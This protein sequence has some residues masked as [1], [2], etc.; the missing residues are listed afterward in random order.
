MARE[1][2]VTRTVVATK[3]IVLGMDTVHCEPFNET[4]VVSGT[5]DDDEKSNAKLLKTVKKLVDT[6]EKVA[7]KI[8][9]KE[10]VETLYGMSE[11]KF[12]ELGEVLPPRTKAETTEEN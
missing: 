5:F 4:L 3:V 2:M 6:E 10:E 8:V 12:M 11:Q 1:R 7:V 9:S